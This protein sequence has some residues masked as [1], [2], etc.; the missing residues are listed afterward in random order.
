MMLRKLQ[1]NCEWKCY[2]LL[3]I[4]YTYIYIY[5]YIYGNRDISLLS[6]IH[7]LN[8][9]AISMFVLHSFRSETWDCL[10]ANN[11]KIDG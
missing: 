3:W 8:I 2:R 7:D 1:M 6:K 11:V 4:I 5:M 9:G 10:C